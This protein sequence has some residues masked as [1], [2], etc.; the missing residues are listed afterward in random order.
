[1]LC[2]GVVVLLYKFFGVTQKYY[3]AYLRFKY[4]GIEEVDQMSGHDFE[5][6][7]APLFETHG[8]KASVTQGSGD[9]GADL[10][11]KNRRK[12][13]VVQAK[14]YSSNIGIA[15]VQQAVG[16]VNFYNA[17]GAMVVTNRYFTK[18][19]EKLAKANNV[20]LINRTELSDMI[21]KY[22]RQRKRQLLEVE[23]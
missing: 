17:N 2:F 12:K 8:F 1:M 13:Y 21:C 23:N 7:L 6:F 3:K 5:H 9:Y 19:A 22:H 20:K 4:S 10:I 11:L 15:A 14:C 16:A 18:Q